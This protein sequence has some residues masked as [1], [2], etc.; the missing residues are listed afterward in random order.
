M[1]ASV[2]NLPTG[3]TIVLVMGAI[4]VASLLAAP[5]RGL[6]WR[7]WRDRRNARRLR[8]ETVLIDL[9]VLAAKHDQIDYAHEE[10]VLDA[11]NAWA[12][13]TRPALEHLEDDGLVTQDRKRRWRLTAAGAEHAR[14]L[15]EERHL[16]F[17]DVPNPER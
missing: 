12:G 15:A 7:W 11:M 9:Y 3:P 13:R 17:T 2:S 8:R 10:S 5:N 14:H 6:L 16:I 1:S 4:V